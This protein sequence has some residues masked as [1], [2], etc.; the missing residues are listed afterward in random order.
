MSWALTSYWIFFEVKKQEVYF[1]KCIQWVSYII[2]E[3]VSLL[4]IWLFY[5]KKI[6]PAEP[7]P[8]GDRSSPEQCSGPKVKGG[9]P[10][11]SPFNAQTP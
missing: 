5:Q 7:R 2:E 8:Q 1:L 4:G 6:C 3:M 10:Q 11:Q 9:C